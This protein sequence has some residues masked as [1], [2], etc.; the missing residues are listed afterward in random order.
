VADRDSR[1]SA[2]PFPREH[3][4]VCLLVDLISTLSD[5]R[6]AA[7]PWSSPACRSRWFAVE[8][9]EASAPIQVEVASSN[10]R[11]NAGLISEPGLSEKRPRIIGSSSGT[12]VSGRRQVHRASTAARISGEVVDNLP[13]SRLGAPTIALRDPI[14]KGAARG[15]S[16]LALGSIAARA[17]H[18]QGLGLHA[19]G[20]K[21]AD[22]AT[23]DY[24]RFR[25]RFF[26]ACAGKRTSATL[27]RKHGARHPLAIDR[28]ASRGS[29][30]RGS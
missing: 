17:A 2:S 10:H 27:L 9:A 15:R 1:G 18:R 22:K 26:E 13:L 3:L 23:R 4:P 8:R 6:M 16:P 25:N 12:G 19:V 30:P 7:S 24:T 14:Y 21:N 5:Y 28:P 29:A 11:A 20:I